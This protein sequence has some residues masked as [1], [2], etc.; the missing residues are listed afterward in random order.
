[1]KSLAELHAALPP[2]VEEISVPSTECPTPQQWSMWD[3]M[4]E[5]LSFLYALVRLLKPV[6]IIETGTYLGYGTAHLA[7]AA[8][9]NK[10]GRVLT[11]EPDNALFNK[12]S[13]LLAELGLS[14]Y[15]THYPV[16]G[17]SMIHSLGPVDFAFLDSNCNARIEEM[18]VLLPRLHQGSM[19]AVHDTSVFHMM[20]NDGP[21][22]PFTKLAED[23]GLEMM[24]FN[25][26]RGLM[27]FR[28]K[29]LV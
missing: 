10:F 7:L 15:V 12:S 14:A 27:L 24:H 5:T 16:I 18:A 8:K 17:T 2:M 22:G 13:M 20:N 28:R 25:T 29:P 19:V 4:V 3:G 6:V 21:R 11:A 9:H 1:L 23:L 26:P